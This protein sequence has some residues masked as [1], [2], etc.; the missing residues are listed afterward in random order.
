MHY[1]DVVILSVEGIFDFE[2]RFP[3]SSLE[4]VS[5]GSRSNFLGDSNPDKTRARQRND[6]GDIAFHSLAE[7]EDRFE[8]LLG[9]TFNTNIKRKSW[10]VLD[11]VVA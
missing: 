2:D 4:S 3:E 11:F 9:R 7:C 5:L 6:P 10:R 1:Y 8:T